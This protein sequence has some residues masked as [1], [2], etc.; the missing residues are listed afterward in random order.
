MATTRRV[1]SAVRHAPRYVYTCTCCIFRAHLAADAL[2][3]R[4]V[5][6]GAD[7]APLRHNV[8]VRMHP[9]RA[10][11][12]SPY[13]AAHL[14]DAAVPTSSGSADGAPQWQRIMAALQTQMEQQR[15]QMDEQQRLLA[16]LLAAPGRVSTMQPLTSPW[17]SAISQPAGV[18][19]VDA[20]SAAMAAARGESHAA[21]VA[22]RAPARSCVSLFHACRRAHMLQAFKPRTND[23]LPRVKRHH[24]LLQRRSHSHRSRRCS[25]FLRRC[26]RRGSRQAHWQGK[27]SR[28]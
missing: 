13:G 22:L 25:T 26:L 21:F 18:A 1:R 15:R 11:A 27:T 2:L 24:G 5:P 19:P 7:S 20:A 4:V 17:P 12:G 23:P 8:A 6:A 16:A 10:G 14:G 3:G 28:L 9:S